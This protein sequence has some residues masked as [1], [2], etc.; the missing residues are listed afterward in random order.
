MS[1]KQI[2]KILTDRVFIFPVI[3]VLAFFARIFAGVTFN[4]YKPWLVFIIQIGIAVLLA[5][6]SYEYQII[7]KKTFLP[8]ALF[9]LFTA[10]NPI[11]Y[12]NL[13]PTISA[14]AMVLCLLISFKNYHNHHSQIG[15][16]NIALILTI[17]SVLCKWPLLLFIPMFWVG[18]VW[19]RAFNA[20]SF[21][22]SL[23]GIF[24]VYLFLFAW[25]VYSKDLNF[26][27]ERLPYFKGIISVDWIELQWY[28]WAVVVYLVLLLLLAAVNIFVSGFSEK[29]RTTLFFKFLYLFVAV[30]FAFICFF[31]FMVNEIQTSIYFAIAFISGFY[32]AMNENNKLV[33]YLLI[34]TFLFFITSYIFRLGIIDFWLMPIFNSYFL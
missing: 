23:L 11:L 3:I 10:S 13:K 8:A 17:G 33:T 2:H 28:D 27:V 16:F 21:F 34:F 24:T 18:F 15:S 25:S 9:L 14:F 6:I 32:F 29:V 31:D 20:R 12:N 19:F 30:L 7:K 1:I 4:E 5:L 22:A 26:F